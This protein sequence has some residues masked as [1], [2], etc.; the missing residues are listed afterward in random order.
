[1]HNLNITKPTHGTH[2]RAHESTHARTYACMHAR[3]HA[4]THAHARMHARTDLVSV[5]RDLN[6]AI[7]GFEKLCAH[8]LIPS[9][10]SHMCVRKQKLHFKRYG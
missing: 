2:A 4:R 9:M 6:G 1:M 8:A 7:H 10:Q 5:G 3:T